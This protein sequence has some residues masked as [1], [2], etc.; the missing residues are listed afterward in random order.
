MWSVEAPID[1]QI[2]TP[3]DAKEIKFEASGNGASNLANEYVKAEKI[4]ATT[5]GYTKQYKLS[6]A[7][8]TTSSGKTAIPQNAWIVLNNTAM[9]NS[10]NPGSLISWWQEIDGVQ[11]GDNQINIDFDTPTS[12]IVLNSSAIVNGVK[13]GDNVAS[14]KIIV[15]ELHIGNGSQKFELQ[16]NKAAQL[17]V[18][19]GK[20]NQTLAHIKANT[21]VHQDGVLN[22][23][24]MSGTY[25]FKL[26]GDLSIKGGVLAVAAMDE[27]EMPDFYVTGKAE[28]NNPRIV[29]FVRT[30]GMM[31]RL[32]ILSAKRGVSLVGGEMSGMLDYA[33]NH[34]VELDPNN[35]DYGFHMQIPSEIYQFSLD[36]QGNVLYANP[37]LSAKAK[38]TGIFK[39][40]NDEK[41]KLALAFYNNQ[42]ERYNGISGEFKKDV[43]LSINGL[44]DYLDSQGIEHV[45]ISTLSFNAGIYSMAL[46]S[47]LSQGMT[48]AQASGFKNIDAKLALISTGVD[49]TLAEAIKNSGNNLLAV[50]FVNTLAQPF[51]NAPI[52]LVN[53][54]KYAIKQNSQIGSLFEAMKYNLGAR[55]SIAQRLSKYQTIKTSKLESDDKEGSEVQEFAEPNHHLWFNLGGGGVING[56]EFGGSA[57]FN[58]G[59]DTQI[60]QTLVGTYLSYGYFDAKDVGN[61]LKSHNLEAGLYARINI[62]NHSVDM[63]AKT[64]FAMAT[65]ELHTQ[66]LIASSSQSNIKHSFSEVS[67]SYGYNFE[68]SGINLKPIVGVD[69]GVGYTPKYSQVGDIGLDF[70]AQIDFS[71]SAN[72][73]VEMRKYFST[74]SYMYFAPTI[75]QEILHTQKDWKLQSGEKF[76]LGNK[77][78]AYAQILLGGEF[79]FSQNWSMGANIGVRQGIYG[80]QD[81]KGAWQNQTQ[82]TGS[83][84]GVYRF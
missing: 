61:I 55:L 73:G 76:E 2:Q 56:G 30:T 3:S 81:V 22:I 62:E 1:A 11:D 13:L 53:E 43:L 5:N 4:G 77:L 72:V 51:N 49:N 24:N 44:A 54:V 57:G 34:F 14:V 59:Y 41:N 68:L 19:N 39:L 50:N 74:S 83:L 64:L 36:A 27:A 80:Y 7:E 26:E 38:Q 9:S 46:D 84:G 82:I 47:R 6:I 75:T 40:V 25:T 31:D 52:G 79:G 37:K 15:K 66:T 12:T 42:V 33:I 69:M 16:D 63:Y 18:I 8:G 23:G 65:Q 70:D 28:L 60:E 48:M 10:G 35:V 17:M 67:V 45:P 71:A 32:K 21:I 20:G 78:K 58:L 29:T